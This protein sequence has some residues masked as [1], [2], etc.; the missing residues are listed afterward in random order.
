MTQA[1]L[2]KISQPTIKRRAIQPAGGHSSEVRL[3]VVDDVPQC[4]AIVHNCL[5]RDGIEPIGLAVFDVVLNDHRHGALGSARTTDRFEL[6]ATVDVCDRFVQSSTR[7]NLGRKGTVDGAPMRID[8][9]GKS[10]LPQAGAGWVFA[11]GSLGATSLS[12][13]LTPRR[14]GNS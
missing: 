1:S 2:G 6:T 9:S 5:A 8:A 4:L 10:G 12:S 7:N 11:D 3:W 13:H 14:C